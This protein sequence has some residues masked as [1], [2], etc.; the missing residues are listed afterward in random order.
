MGNCEEEHA[1]GAIAFPS[2]DLGETFQLSDFK[3]PVDHTFGSVIK[4]YSKLFDLQAE[5]HGIDKIHRDIFYVPEDVK[6]SLA[7]QTV[8]WTNDEGPQSIPLQP[9]ITYVLP[10][11]YKV[12][13]IKPFAGMR[14]RLIGTTAEGTFCHKP[15]TVSGGGKSEIS[16]SISD[17]M[18]SGPV[19]INDF[20][21]DFDA[22]GF[23]GTDGLVRIDRLNQPAS[24]RPRRPSRRPRR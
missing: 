19:L 16:K 11:G 13:M 23:D 2:F 5:G 8:S 12:E 10:S 20:K 22:A 3:S 9:G 24:A 1:G 7:T 18:L 6:I 15:C 17:A 21:A 14:W 4:N